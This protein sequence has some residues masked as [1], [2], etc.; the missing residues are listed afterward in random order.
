MIPADPRE[1][2]LLAGEYVLGTLEAHEAREVEAALPVNPAL[3]SAVAGWEAR[4][5]PL[6]T[7]A[8]ETPPP[9]ELWTRIDASLTARGTAELRA[10]RD[11]VA[12]P[13]TRVRRGLLDSVGF[14][15]WTTAA[16]ALAAAALAAVLLRPTP[17]PPTP[18]RYLAVLQTDR[19][20]PAWVVE[21]EG[22]GIVLT[23]LNPIDPDPGRV[24]ELWAVPPGATAPLSLG[25]IPPAGRIEL[26]ELPAAPEAGMLIVI[27]LEPTGGSPTGLPT[28]P[29]LFVGR[30]EPVVR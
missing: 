27:S 10:A 1:L 9:P 21:G 24:F 30:L 7:L 28:G 29:Q 16:G 26:R 13:R 20:Q 11:I 12:A 25:V 18:E 23:A 14:W 22:P 6:A 2:D 19:A 8:G 3:R 17:P 5:A 4:L 15:R